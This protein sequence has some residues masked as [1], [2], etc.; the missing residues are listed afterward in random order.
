VKSHA[1]SRDFADEL[2]RSALTDIP[3][4][5][6]PHGRFLLMFAH[7]SL[8]FDEESVGHIPSIIRQ[9]R[10]VYEYHWWGGLDQTR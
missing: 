9:M 10:S 7:R 1:Y 6:P 5:P 4:I 8:L 3:Q 2:L